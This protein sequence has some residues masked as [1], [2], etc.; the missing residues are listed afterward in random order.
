MTT[1]DPA[2]A[3]ATILVVDVGGTSVKFGFN[4]KDRPHDYVR[5]FPA[6]DLRTH[7]PIARLAAMIDTV[8]EETALSFR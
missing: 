5:L 6:A 4:V 2:R 8:I 7:D 3:G 1:R